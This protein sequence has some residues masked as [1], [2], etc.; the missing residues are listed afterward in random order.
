[1]AN[2]RFVILV[3]DI[4][5]HGKKNA[6]P[7]QDL[8][9][10]YG[11]SIREIQKEIE[12]E[13]LKGYLI[14]SSTTAGYWIAESYDDL[15]EFVRVQSARVKSMNRMMQSARKKMRELEKGGGMDG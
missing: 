4:L 15:A 13:R 12:Q 6:T 2:K 5:N 11:C 10:F 1:M 3:Y 9:N 14:C 7:V 8:A